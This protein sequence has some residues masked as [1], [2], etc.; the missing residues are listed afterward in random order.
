[1]AVA[2]HG[3]YRRRTGKDGALAFMWGVATFFFGIFV[4]A[5]YFLVCDT[6][7]RDIEE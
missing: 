6:Y 2:I 3:N 5:I 1:M 7:V 4:V